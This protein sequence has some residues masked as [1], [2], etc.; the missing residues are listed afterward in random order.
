MELSDHLNNILYKKVCKDI[1]FHVRKYLSNRESRLASFQNKELY[2]TLEAKLK[3]NKNFEP[4]KTKK[5]RFT[6]LIL[7]L[8]THLGN[9]SPKSFHVK[10]LIPLIRTWDCHPRLHLH[11]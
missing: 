10:I 5:E 3:D 11:L 1:S 8:E 7:K 4:Y 2:A 6:E 9:F